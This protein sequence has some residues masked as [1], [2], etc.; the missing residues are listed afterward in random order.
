M[1][2]KGHVCNSPR[3]GAQHAVHQARIG[4]HYCPRA[5]VYP[6]EGVTPDPHKPYD[7]E[8]DKAQIRLHTKTGCF[9]DLVRTVGLLGDGFLWQHV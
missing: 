3:R 2:F 9:G 7:T 5:L 4:D 8:R 6:H 1:A